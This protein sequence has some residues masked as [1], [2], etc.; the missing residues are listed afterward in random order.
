MTKMKRLAEVDDSLTPINTPVSEESIKERN[1]LY[2][3]LTPKQFMAQFN[4]E[5]YRPVHFELY[6]QPHYIQLNYCANP[7]CSYYGK[8]QTKFNGRAKRYRLSGKENEKVII[9]GKGNGGFNEI[10]SLGCTT[11]TLSNWSISTE[12]ER[13]H[14]INT[15]LPLDQTYIFHKDDCR[16]TTTPFSSSKDFYK[17]GTSTAK[18][19]RYQC[20]VCKKFTNVLP[21]KKRN[22]GYH[23]QRNDI[24]IQ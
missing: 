13:L 15:V 7:Y 21:D 12:I 19:Q 18:S 6:G 4:V 23:Q 17:R 1:L 20:K 22:T 2:D 10:P 24:L 5:I 3:V 16:I 8:E 14:R 9:C 11:S